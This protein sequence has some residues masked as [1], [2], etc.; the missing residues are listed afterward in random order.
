MGSVDLWFLDDDADK[1][2]DIDLLFRFV[3]LSYTWWFWCYQYCR[4][5]YEEG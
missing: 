2:E 4:L 1:N 5:D 3:G